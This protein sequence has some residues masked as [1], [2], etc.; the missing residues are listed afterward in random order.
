M[1]AYRA[2]T[3]IVSLLREV[4]ARHDDARSLGRRIFHDEVDLKPDLNASTL[5]VRLHHL[6][7]NIHD[8]AVRHLCEQLN[9]TETT[10]PGTS[11]RMIY[12]LGSS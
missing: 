7:E 1:I 12:E 9:T 10:F 4:L 2:E 11:L 6:G 5:T 3:S 8:A